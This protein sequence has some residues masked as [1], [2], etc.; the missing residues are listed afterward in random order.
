MPRPDDRP[1]R[2]F[3]PGRLVPIAV[4]SAGLSLF[5][6]F[7]L[8]HY[9]TLETLKTQRAWLSQQV[10]E[11]AVLTAAVYILVYVVV[12]AF[13]LPVAALVTI[14]GGFLFGLAGGTAL[15]VVGATLGAIVL[16][17]AARTA[18]YD[19]LHARAGPALRK[20]EDGFREDALSYMLVLRLV[21]LFPFFVVN[22]VP[23]LL[24][25]PLRI[26]AIGTFFGIIPGSLV[27]TWVGHGLGAVSDAGEAPDLGIVWSPSV[28]GPLIGLA[29][30]AVIPVVYR[31]L[32]ARKTITRH[33][34]QN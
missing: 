14:T 27:Y 26:F 13:S 3:S 6:A 29:V 22:F 10:A 34:G 8:H 15:S 7:D 24:G 28:L 30:L 31:H 16:F 9:V 32:K 21:P 33:S 20:M 19:L 2:R 17:I 4:L 11:N 18:F 12:V 5:F 23:A 25:V 1:S